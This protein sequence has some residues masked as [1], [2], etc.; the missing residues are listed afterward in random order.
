[1]TDQIEIPVGHL[2]ALLMCSDPWPVSDTGFGEGREEMVAFANTV[3]Q[4]MGFID[5][6]DAYH[7]TNQSFR[8]VPAA[9]SAREGGEAVA[10]ARNSGDPNDD[11]F[12]ISAKVKRL[13]L[14]SN[15]KRVARYTRPLYTTHVPCW[16]L[17]AV[18]SALS[19]L[20]LQGYWHSDLAAF[21]DWLKEKSQ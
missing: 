16:A 7:G 12:V 20:D 15:P 8:Y 21:R 18:E 13:W 11:A 2:F 9:L 10:W 3:A 6:T 1:M 17:P 5:W 14:A 4:R 19:M